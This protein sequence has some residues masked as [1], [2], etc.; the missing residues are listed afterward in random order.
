MSR[1]KQ[2]V[3]EVGVQFTGLLVDSVN[4]VFDMRESDTDPLPQVYAGMGCKY[5]NGLA[6]TGRK[7]RII[8]NIKNIQ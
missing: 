2:I 8:L 6:K 7:V 1:G 4:E 3:F 5:I